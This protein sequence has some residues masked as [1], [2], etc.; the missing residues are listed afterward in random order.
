MP[1]LGS[2]TFPDGGQQEL[3]D[4]EVYEQLRSSTF[5]DG[6]QQERKAAPSRAS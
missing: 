1:P 5:P 6:G 2:S 3:R 4:L